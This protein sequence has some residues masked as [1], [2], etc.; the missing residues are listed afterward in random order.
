M[1]NKIIAGIRVSK[2]VYMNKL[3]SFLELYFCGLYN[4]GLQLYVTLEAIQSQLI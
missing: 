1:G 3:S 4:E 2:V